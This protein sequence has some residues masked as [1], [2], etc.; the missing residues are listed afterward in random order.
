MAPTNR[1]EMMLQSLA[2]LLKDSGDLILDGTS[3]LTL[4]TTTL[5]ILTQI[6]EQHLIPRNQNHGFIALSSHPAET[7]AILQAQFLF[8]VLQKTLSLKLIHVPDC[9]LPA[10]V[11]IFPFKSLRRLELKC[12]PLHCLRGLRLVYSQLEALTCSKCVSSLEEIISACG[13]DLSSALPW[14]ELQSVNFSYNSIA[15]L[16][17]SLQLLNA[18]KA[19]DLSHNELQ[20][21]EHYLTVLTELEYLNVAY[22]SLPKMPDLGL[23]SQVKLMTLILRYNQ[24]DS[25]NG[26]ER[27]PL[28][29]HL[30]VAYNL[31]L[32]HTLLEPLSLL[33]NLKKLHLEGNPL[34]FHKNHLPATIMHLSLRA[35]SSNFFLDEE[36]LSASDL[37][38][39]PKLNRMAAQPVCTPVSER[40]L[41][42]RSVLESSCMADQSDSQSTGESKLPT[43]KKTKGKVKRV[44][45]A[46]ISEPS[47]TEHEYATQPLSTGIVQQHQ[48]EMERMDSFR[49]RFGPHWLQYRR[50]LEAEGQAGPI[51]PS[52]SPTTDS[53]GS[54]NGASEQSKNR[55]QEQKIPDVVK[56]KEVELPQAEVVVEGLQTVVE[57][58]GLAVKEEK[59][60]E[61]KLEVD[62]CQPVLVSQIEGD[63]DPEPDWIFLRVT[64]QHVM[65]VEL[66]AARVLHRLELQS[67]Q[68]VETSEMNWRRMELERAF[69]VLTLH[70]SYICKDRQK[71]RYIVLDD[72]PEL[73]VQNLL[74][75]LAP[76]LEKNQKKSRDDGGP[77]LQCLKCKQEFAGGLLLRR[78][79]P[80][81]AK[82]TP[83]FSEQG[84]AGRSEPIICPSCSSDHVIILP[85]ERRSS[86]PLPSQ[87][88]LGE[89]QQEAEAGKFYIGEE[90]NSEMGTYSSSRTQEL[91]SDQSSAAHSSSHS[92]EADASRKDLSSKGRDS[93][94][95]HTDTN[96]GS[97][98]GS[99]HYGPSRGPTPSQ[100]S[101]SLEHEEHWN[102]SP[103]TNSLLGMRDFSSVDHRL[104][105]YLDMEVFEESEEFKCFLKVAV[106]KNGRLGEFLALLVASDVQFYVL[107]VKGEIRGQPS[108]WLK[109]SDSHYLSDLS[110]LEVGLC[111]QS[112]HVEFVNPSASY[113]LLLR[114][115]S[116][117]K[118]FLQC[119][120]Y[121]MQ[122][123]PVKSRRKVPEITV[124]EMNPQHLLW[125]LLEKDLS[126]EA[127]GS[128]AKPFFYLLAYLI[129]G[130]SAFPVTL[131][132]TRSNLFL[133]E[134]DHQKQKT[135]PASGLG[136][137]AEKQLKNGFQLKENQ[138]ISSIS[139][140][141]LY[142]FFPCDVK[143]QLYDEVLKVESTWHLRTEC[144]DLLADLVEWLRVPWEEMFSI[145]LRKKVLEVLE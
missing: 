34:C 38:H 11:K 121:L 96:G 143:L 36:P 56:G 51:T 5:Q 55:V 140:V 43:R 106:V 59:D 7:S 118:R 46:S 21:C 44:R 24:L 120:T 12:V 104:K 30:D 117:C 48:A 53:L 130:A 40:A 137:D 116:R 136:S 68:K 45:R 79:T 128:S 97:L 127:A 109:K 33:H 125:P 100:L 23:H 135:P 126:R 87:E 41:T 58:N 93:S 57:T 22:N 49:E 73:C 95:S 27:L 115:Q 26:V 99:Y 141:V 42:D 29:Q 64:A 16:D 88:C 74:R 63:C 133:V 65:E 98:M 17:D 114:N 103:P 105:L 139:G 72:D 47:D 83:A 84:I 82:G 144:P 13:G 6:F 18:L 86:T 60:Q 8:D 134:E 31:L 90:T 129:Q 92:S 10:A 77:K 32:D 85:C 19:L 119:L 102:L 3:T 14:L 142:H 28:L 76:T 70:F 25:I 111:H 107:E 67:L 15:T 94:L 122:E 75:V 66:K 39:L 101:L 132:S 80:G 9:S 62:L 113:N 35:I 138:P 4:Y 69:P 1:K 89:S 108:D 110:H 124:T 37:Q 112:L 61:E 145:S 91:S 20:D 2:Q 52:Q 71:R 78:E 50:H 81:P 131:L 123:L 54:S